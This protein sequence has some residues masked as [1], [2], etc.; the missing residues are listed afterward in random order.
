MRFRLGVASTVVLASIAACSGGGSDSSTATTEP[1]DTTTTTLVEAP[2]ESGTQ[3]FVFNPSV[4]DCFDRRILDPEMTGNTK[5]TEI[6][7]LLACDLPHRNEVFDVVTYRSP[8]GS[9]GYPGE[10]TLRTYAKRNCIANFA[11]YIGTEYELSVFDVGYVIPNETNWVPG[12]P[13]I[14]CYVY[15]PTRELTIGSAR[16]ARR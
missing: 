16:D 15:D 11:D 6:T 3:L 4:G 7:L 9:T 1:P 10:T 8:D 2:L 14:G 12:N 5:Q 13:A